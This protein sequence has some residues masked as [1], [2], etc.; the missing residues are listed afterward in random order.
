MKKSLSRIIP[1]FIVFWIFVYNPGISPSAENADQ[2]NITDKKSETADTKVGYLENVLFEKL[3]GKE[4]IN[5]VVSQQPVINVSTQADGSLL[6]KLENMSAPDNLLGSLGEGAL[7]NVV[8]VKPMQQLLDGKQFIYLTIDLKEN[9]P[10]A[11][12]QEEKN[13]FIDF[14]IS[15]LVVKKPVKSL[16][17]KGKNKKAAAKKKDMEKISEETATF[18]DDIDINE[19][20]PAKKIIP[21]LNKDRIITLDFQDADIKTVLRLMAE[22]GNISI[23]SGEDVKGKVTLTIKN[24]PWEQALDSILETQG[25][26]KKVMGDV[27]TV[28]TLE[29]KKKEESDRKDAERDQRTAEDERKARETKLLS[30]KGKLRQILIEAKIVE[31]TQDFIRNIGINWGFG[32]NQSIGSYGSGITGGTSTLQTNTWN[33]PYPPEITAKNYGTISKYLAAVNMPAALASPTLGVIFGAG[34]SFLEAQLAALESD[35]TGRI[36]SAPKVVTMDNVKAVM[37]QG[38]DVPYITQTVTTAGI[39]TTVTFKEAVLKL[40]VK[41]RITD[42]GKISMEI[43]C[44]NDVPDYAM[45]A[46]LFGNPPIHKNE[47]ESTVVIQDGDTVVIGGVLR[48]SD[49][50]VV[51]GIPWVY[52][53]P[54]FGWLFKTEN[55]TKQKRQLLVFITPKILKVNDVAGNT[56]KS[57]N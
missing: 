31:A 21:K 4:R 11:I 24:T 55:L 6:V 3:P 13:I 43:K 51:S 26:A 56:E 14:N 19:V 30:E 35:T 48:D 54:I 57:I 52:K 38:D 25:L 41:P 37:K 8:R 9:V 20:K 46:Q 39:T 22:Y 23:I 42:D 34:T 33:Q 50:K 36:I 45:A 2:R 28:M 29:R 7:V 15:S 49:Q 17:A 40:E 10:Y 18:S 32:G 1:V 12:R 27:I 5:L 53:I 47:V 16:A 44:G